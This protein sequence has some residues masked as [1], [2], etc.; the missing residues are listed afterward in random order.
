MTI[1]PVP[2]HVVSVNTTLPPTFMAEELL[3]LNERI[4]VT[5]KILLTTVLFVIVNA[6]DAPFKVRL[7]KLPL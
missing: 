6:N 1:R 2:V 5:V 3:E 7:K 4:V